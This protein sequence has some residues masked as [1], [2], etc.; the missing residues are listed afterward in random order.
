MSFSSFKSFGHQVAIPKLLKYIIM[1]NEFLKND[2]FES[3]FIENLKYYNGFTNLE[4]QTFKWISG[5][6]N[7]NGGSGPAI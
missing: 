7:A 4:K 3:P 6:N 1:E 5:G 2:S